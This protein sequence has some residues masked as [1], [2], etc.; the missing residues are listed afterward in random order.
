MS[1]Y[2]MI[3]CAKLFSAVIEGKKTIQFS[4]L[5]LRTACEALKECADQQGNWNND[6]KDLYKL[7]VDYAE[8][9]SRG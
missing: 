2:E 9:N 1:F 3:C 5:E 6:Q 4:E 8:E 7:M